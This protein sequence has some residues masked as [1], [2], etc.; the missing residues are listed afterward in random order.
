MTCTICGTVLSASS[1]NEKCFG[2]RKS[3]RE[4]NILSE[5]EHNKHENSDYYN[6]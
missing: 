1:V 6:E 3:V 2:R 5:E 4:S